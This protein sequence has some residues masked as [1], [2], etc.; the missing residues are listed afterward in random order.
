MQPCLWNAEYAI[1][2]DPIMQESS[3]KSD[4]IVLKKV[5]DH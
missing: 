5:V 1:M 3:I 4:N 2:Y